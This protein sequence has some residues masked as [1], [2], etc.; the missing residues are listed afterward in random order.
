MESMGYRMIRNCVGAEY[1]NVICDIA[2][3][4]RRNLIF[5]PSQASTRTKL[6]KYLPEDVLQKLVDECG[7]G[8]YRV[9]KNDDK[10]DARTLRIKAM[11]DLSK[12][13]YSEPDICHIL[14]VTTKTILD[15][16]CKAE[17][18]EDDKTHELQLSLF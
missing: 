3:H 8:R 18:K 10:M 12:I 16:Y 5:I 17:Q 11:N 1:I 4:N 7:G 2:D 9:C 15:D 14:N 13:G 6:H